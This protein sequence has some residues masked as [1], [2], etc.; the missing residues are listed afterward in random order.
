MWCWLQRFNGATVLANLVLKQ[1]AVPFLNSISKKKIDEI[2]GAHKKS[3]K[4]SECIKEECII[5]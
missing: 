3:F 5:M 4:S 2:T 1:Y